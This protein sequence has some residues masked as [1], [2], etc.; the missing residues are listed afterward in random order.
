[1]RAQG[2]E[3]NTI[4]VNT[5]LTALA[6]SDDGKRAVIKADSIMEDTRSGKLP[7]LL[8]LISFNAY[9]DCLG[10]NGAPNAF[11][12]VEETLER[13]KEVGVLPDRI[14]FNTAMKLLAKSEEK[15]SGK[16]AV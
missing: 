2:V 14:T 7:V 5:I 12:R 1:M 3:P 10:R 9:L 15:G 11:Q 8:D 13:M 4:T 6:R 16:M